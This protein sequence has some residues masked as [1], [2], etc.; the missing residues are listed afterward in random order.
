MEIEKQGKFLSTC[1]TVCVCVFPSACSSVR[2]SGLPQLFCQ[3]A[4]DFLICEKRARGGQFSEKPDS[5]RISHNFQKRS[6]LGHK[7]H[8][9]WIIHYN[10]SMLNFCL[11]IANQKLIKL[12]K[13]V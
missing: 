7:K 9:C 1:L 4:K 3:K 2:T 8:V 12:L 11:I 13:H 10:E 6:Y 5:A